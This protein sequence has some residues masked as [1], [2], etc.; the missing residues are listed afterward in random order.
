MSK[1]IYDMILM[2]ISSSIMYLLAQILYRKTHQKY[3]RWYYSMLVTALLMLILP[4]QSVIQIPKMMK[5]TIPQN[6]N[7]ESAAEI[8]P[9]SVGI[10]VSQVVFAIWAA[11]VVI[12]LIRMVI[13]YFRTRSLL[14][15][16]SSKTHDEII[17]KAYT[18][19][20]SSIG[21]HRDIA[22]RIS[23]YIHSP[24]LF[25]IFKPMIIIPENS[26]TY[27]ELVMIMSHEL[28]HYKHR[29]LL[30]KLIAS[31]GVCVHWFNPVSYLLSKSLNNACELC[32]DESVLDMLD[33]DD[34]KEYGR[35]IISVI[36]ASFN[37]NLAYTT[38]MAS[39]ECGIQKRLLKIV[40][41]RSPSMLVKI[42]CVMLLVSLSVCSVTALGVDFAKEV[43][44]DDTVQAIEKF[45]NTPLFQTSEPTIV[46]ESV[47][48]ENSEQDYEENTK[49]LNGVNVRNTEASVYVNSY[50]DVSWDNS[51]PVVTEVPE[52]EMEI[53]QPPEAEMEDELKITQPPK[54]NSMEYSPAPEEPIKS[55]ETQSVNIVISDSVNFD[56]DEITD[57][58]RKQI[59]AVAKEDLSVQDGQ[60][61]KAYIRVNDDGSY[62]LMRTETE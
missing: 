31:V 38:A 24:L 40:E 29:D 51:L 4:I 17:I 50:S 22:V 34:K 13:K 16:I 1:H 33:L 8:F 19:V 28:M 14:L 42:I 32:C 59:E 12:M 15:S 35:L 10:T 3:A 37:S 39:S 44:P 53:T 55:E 57:S 45:E 41:F 46:P 27:D 36:E 20:S 52:T 30:I 48:A 61:V 5:I 49:A 47:P 58:N 54:T 21:V 62:D 56:G 7:I 9:S 26:F 2:G 18:Y 25:G 60:E 6:I 11:V 43:L 23:G